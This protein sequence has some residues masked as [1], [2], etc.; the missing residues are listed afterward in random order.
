MT[1]R[2]FSL[3]VPQVS[4]KGFVVIDTE[5]TGGKEDSRVIE[6]GMAFLSPR[7]TLQ[8]TFSTLL[9][10]D[11]TAGEWYVKRVHR[12]R[13]SD[14]VGAPKFKQIAPDFLESIQGRILVAHNANFDL[15]R[16]NHELSLV[17]RRQVQ[18]MACTIELGKY[19]GYGSL[20]LE[21][22]IDRFNLFRQISHHAIHDA[23]A[24]SQLLK[25]YLSEDKQR[26]Y[27]YLANKGFEI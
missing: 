19:L 12:I 23:L 4:P 13:D 15:K 18:N 6:L 14:L 24:T 27:E 5:T 1:S 7:G 9:Y 16:I 26:V 3:S 2:G 17:R 8:N 10:G 25:H 21:K 11:G 22:A 20:S